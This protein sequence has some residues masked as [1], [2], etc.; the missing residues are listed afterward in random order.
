MD[1]VMNVNDWYLFREAGRGIAFERVVKPM[2][3]GLAPDEEVVA[4]ALPRARVVVEE[5][6]RLLGEQDYFT[7][8]EVSLADLLVGP[9]MD[10]LSETPEWAAL[11][12]PHANLVAWLARM[13]A[14]PSFETTTFTRVV[15]MAQA[16]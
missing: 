1:Q 4:A 2:I 13:R 8:D 15:E 14:R 5:L 6:A 12:A 16:A 7:G 3:L 9:Q 11:G 10:M